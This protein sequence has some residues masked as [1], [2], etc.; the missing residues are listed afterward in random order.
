MEMISGDSSDERIALKMG[1]SCG[2]FAKI[3]SASTWRTGQEQIKTSKQI[4]NE[5]FA[6][7]NLLT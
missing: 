5:E 1:A 3:S 2:L 7:V 4:T 6:N